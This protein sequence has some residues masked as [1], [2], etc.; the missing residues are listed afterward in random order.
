[1]VENVT[2]TL[3]NP[4]G[5]LVTPAL[6]T[7]AA[8]ATITDNDAAT[9]ISIAADQPDTTEG[10]S[11]TFT[12]TR[13]GDAQ[14]E[15]TVDWAV[16]GDFE[17]SDISSP[18]TGQVT[19]AEGE[20]TKTITVVTVDDLLDEVVENVTVTLSNPTGTLV[21]PALGTAA[22]SATI[23]DNDAATSISIAADQPDTTEGGSLTFT[24]TR[25]GDAQGEQTVDWAVTGDFEASDI[26]SPLTGQV[27]FAEGE[28][29]KTITV[30][31]V[32][33]LLDEVVENVTVTLSNPT[34]TLVTPALGTAA[35][36][37]TITDNDAATSI[38]IAADQPDT[39]EGGS[40]TFTVTRTGDAQGEQT[41]DW[42]VTGDFEASDISSPLTGQVTFAEGET[43]KTITVVTVDDL[44]DE[45]AENVTVT[46]SN[47]TG[48][49]V[50][51]ALGTAAASATITDNDAATSISIAA[52][53]PDTT[54]GGS[55]TFTVTRTGD[56]EGEQTVGLRALRRS[57][58]PISAA[59]CR[60]T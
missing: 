25:T 22:A 48:T 24:V 55:L 19:F 31:T 45:V 46:L 37:A 6:G 35:A 3:S 38:S 8:S 2:V 42:A 14:G 34:G 18:L 11:L 32:D 23:T 13:T 26:S 50:T 39:T 60:R 59:R 36:S 1:M 53:Q 57:R 33:D 41:V 15:Q 30:V 9:S 58:P 10:G 54:E 43:T 40:L 16:T 49:L 27:T 51:P 44:L 5:T 52:D 56:A 4:T 47:P 20:T 7:A 12:V 28:T 17:A 29:T 21:T